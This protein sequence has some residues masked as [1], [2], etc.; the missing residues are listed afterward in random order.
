MTIG[1]DTLTDYHPEPP[2]WK[3]GWFQC[4]V[5]AIVVFTGSLY[6]QFVPTLDNGE[7]VSSSIGLSGTDGY[8]HAKMGYLYRT[9]E[10]QDAG[11][12]FHWTRE[13]TWNH[14]FSDKDYLFHWFVAPF[15]LIADG[16]ADAD[17]L[18]TA[19]KLSAAVLTTLVILALFGALRAFGVRHSW[20]WC[21]MAV[22]TGAGY[23]VFRVNL[24]RSYL[25]SIA[26]AL[27]GWVLI[28]KERR[29]SLFF[30][31]VVYTLTYT[32][33]HLLLAMLVVKAATE[34]FFGP[35]DGLT[36]WIEL[37]R[38]AI[39]ALVIVGGIFLGLLLHPQPMEMA[40]LWWTQNV[41]VLAY[42]HQGTIA[43]ALDEIAGILGFATEYSKSVNLSL[44]RELAPADGP[45]L[46]LS[47]PLI[48]FGPMLISLVYAMMGVR[49]SRNMILCGGISVA[50]LVMYMINSR[51][52]E[53]AGPF[54]ALFL[55][56]AVSELTQTEAWTRFKNRRPNG[57]AILAYGL[58]G[59][60]LMAATAIWWGAAQSNRVTDRGKV[61]LAGR[62]LHE[63]PEAH[64]KVVWHDRWDDFTKLIFYASECDYLI[65]LD[66]T[67]MLANDREKYEE[68]HAIK[69][70][71]RHSFVET[72]RDDFDADYILVRRSSSDYFYNRCME[73]AKA[74]RLKLCI[75]ADDD[76][77]SL[78]QITAPR[79]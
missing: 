28:V 76:A 35:R 70:G 51:F 8:Y 5:I 9:G 22:V 29:G 10:V 71:K 36:R 30:V 57:E 37:R 44:G 3:R 50:W 67:F 17:G 20:F 47:T 33:S 58:C 73:E 13:S 77:W 54:S 69:T 2:L 32:A 43:P 24:C 53:Y 25:A 18:I 41:V 23:F 15:T 11:A 46:A 19:G 31:A 75:R 62:W 1:E 78:Y 21:L 38:N 56:V 45:D 52:L 65:G 27:V 49:P 61:E 74:G 42:S 4:V 63:H 68:W 40:K 48:V 59:A 26:L 14:S 7:V 66:P 72:I 16:P 12:N 39:T 60:G 6:Y 55:G 34:V 64:G 79:E